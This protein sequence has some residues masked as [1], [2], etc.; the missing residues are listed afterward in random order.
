MRTTYLSLNHHYDTPETA[1]LLDSVTSVGTLNEELHDAVVM[2]ARQIELCA[3]QARSLA[4]SLTGLRKRAEQLQNRIDPTD[5]TDSQRAESE[6]IRGALHTALTDYRATETHAA[7]TITDLLAGHSGTAIL[8]RAAARSGAERAVALMRQDDLT[9]SE[10]AELDRLLATYAENDDFAGYLLDTLGVAEL[11]RQS[12]RFETVDYLSTAPCSPGD[13]R[14]AHSLTVGLAN[15]FATATRTPDHLKDA[16][17]ESDEF[18]AWLRTPEGRD[19]QRRTDAARAFA[20][21]P[22]DQSMLVDLRQYGPLLDLMDP[23]SAPY[24]PQF[25][26]DLVADMTDGPAGSSYEGVRFDPERR[27]VDRLLGISSRN[28]DAAAMIVDPDRNSRAKDWIEQVAQ[29]DL[30]TSG[31]GEPDPQLTKG[32]N[33]LLGAAATGLVEGTDPTTHA[34]PPSAK[35]AQIAQIII[36][37][38]AT[39]EGFPPPLAQAL[40]NTTAL[41]LGNFN[42]TLNGGVVPV[43]EHGLDLDHSKAVDV[44]EENGKY[45]ESF[46][47]VRQ[48]QI[49]YAGATFTYLLSDEVEFEEATPADAANLAA[50]AGGEVI[51]V[52]TSTRADAVFAEETEGLNNGYKRL[53]QHFLTSVTDTTVGRVPAF[54]TAAGNEMIRANES[55]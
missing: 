42:D 21:G 14:P 27:D 13:R 32:L 52:L 29:R 35:N 10:L 51:G 12:A 54:G 17:P 8:E 53:S 18:R 4:R 9:E 26:D 7:R 39:D 55:M 45:E 40:G 15:V 24:S 33:Q 43:F 28:P 48:G 46:D 20:A 23:A 31:M 19:W 49:A 11:A 50:R 38:A 6:A 44:L 47:I 5:I 1:E 2:A 34:A 3:E 41:Y 16:P 36:D 30:L 22:E 37:Q 25:L